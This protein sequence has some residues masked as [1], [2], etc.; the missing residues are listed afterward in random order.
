MPAHLD[1]KQPY[2]Q[3]DVRR[4]LA[5][6]ENDRDIQLRISDAGLA[7]LEEATGPEKLEGVHC[8][9]ETWDAGNDYCGVRAAQNTEWVER[10]YRALGRNWP[11][12]KSSTFEIL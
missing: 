2:T 4:L 10:I 11:Q 3:D 12:R 9:G 1:L 6:K 5:S 7:Y 8:R